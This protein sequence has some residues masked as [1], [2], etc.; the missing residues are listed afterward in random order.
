MNNKS[1]ENLLETEDIESLDIQSLD[2][3]NSNASHSKKFIAEIQSDVH[4][5]A[6]KNFM[7]E[8]SDSTE[9]KSLDRPIPAARKLT[10]APIASKRNSKELK[11]DC[12]QM[13][14]KQSLPSDD[15]I[16][17]INEKNTEN[18]HN[19]NTVES[20]SEKRPKSGKQSNIELAPLGKEV[21]KSK[22]HFVTN[23]TNE[24]TTSFISYEEKHEKEDN[25]EHNQS[26]YRS[27]R[28]GKNSLDDKNGGRRNEAFVDSDENIST[29]KPNPIHEEDDEVSRTKSSKTKSKRKKI[30]SKKHKRSRHSTGEEIT[31]DSSGVQNIQEAYDFKKL[32]G[33][34]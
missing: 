7:V 11:D 31:K 21:K 14:W 16:H 15:T 20:N 3:E 18:K 13:V 6:K 12:N 4:K 23:Q 30:K 22:K 24:E 5:K 33:N 27:S 28:I 34:Y 8:K 19:S 26:S 2:V 17:T 32:I 29:P 25:S 10:L 9:L 1:T